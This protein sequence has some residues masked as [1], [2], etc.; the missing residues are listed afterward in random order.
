MK[1]LVIAVDCDDVLIGAT[2]YLV[3]EYNR[4]YNTQV[5]KKQAHTSKNPQWAA[6]RDEVFR[7]LHAIQSSKE[8]ATIIP[9]HQTIK[10][11]QQLAKHHE[12][13]LVTARSS[14]VIAVTFS[15]VEKYFPDCFDSI[16]H[17]GADVPKG[18]YCAAISADVLID[19]NLKNL[20]GAYECGI[21]HLLWFGEYEWQDGNAGTVQ[22]V[23]C[24]DWPSAEDE[25]ERIA[26]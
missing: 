10:A 15:M 23:R 11:I 22:V 26:S 19:D 5:E 25:I 6:E 9:T 17:V 4:L 13:H 24:Y 2:D 8:Y 12:L 21:K 14:D 18:E 1:R 16:E 7:R 20:E 3:E